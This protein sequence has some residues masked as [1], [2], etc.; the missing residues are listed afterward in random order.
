M[1]NPV[2]IIT[3]KMID[4]FNT[5]GAYD[6]IVIKIIIIVEYDGSYILN[7]KR[8]RDVSNCS[9]QTLRRIRELHPAE[10]TLDYTVQNFD[11]LVKRIQ[12][13]TDDYFCQASIAIPSNPTLSLKIGSNDPQ[14]DASGIP[15]A[16]ALSFIRQCAR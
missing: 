2:L 15:V 11:N 8:N 6:E 5:D 10:E 4:I 13:L 7:I 12:K 14:L 16:T 9:L 1:A 3:G